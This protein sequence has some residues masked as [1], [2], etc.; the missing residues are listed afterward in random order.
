MK[1]DLNHLRLSIR[2]GKKVE[3][4]K[5]QY[6]KRKTKYKIQIMFIVVLYKKAVIYIDK[7]KK[8][9]EIKRELNKSIKG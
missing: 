5:N 6:L 3:I 7:G 2:R 8:E 4:D 9:N 1:I